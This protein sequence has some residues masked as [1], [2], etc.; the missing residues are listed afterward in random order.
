MAVQQRSHR[1]R[2]AISRCNPFRQGSGHRDRALQDIG[3]QAR[4]V[5]SNASSGSK[6][7]EGD[8][9]DERSENSGSNDDGGSLQARA[10]P[11]LVRFYRR[12]ATTIA[13]YTMMDSSML[14][15]GLFS[16]LHRSR[17]LLRPSSSFEEPYRLG[18]PATQSSPALRASSSINSEDPAG[19]R[20]RIP[21]PEF[22]N[23]S[24][25]FRSEFPQHFLEA[26]PSPTGHASVGSGIS[27]GEGDFQH[28]LS[29]FQN[30]LSGFQDQP[31]PLEDRHR[32]EHFHQ[33]LDS[34]FSLTRHNTD[35]RTDKELLSGEYIVP[36][37]PDGSEHSDDFVEICYSTRVPLL[38]PVNRPTEDS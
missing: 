20:L 4:R 19:S 9:D 38:R 22:P 6:K 11:T 37:S 33:P 29:V 17:S 21:Q 13:D 25:T 27:P 26:L 23:I 12:T 16:P 35:N 8:H 7:N 36:S 30:Q 1:F 14:N 34:P 15:Q 24:E 3:D 5:S 32:V 2:H 18:T 28:Q 31:S 10:G